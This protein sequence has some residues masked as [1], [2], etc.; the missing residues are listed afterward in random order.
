MALDELRALWSAVGVDCSRRGARVKV[1]SD[2][3]SF[4]V[5]GLYRQQGRTDQSCGLA[6]TRSDSKSRFGYLLLEQN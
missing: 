5:A 4:T 1:S 2:L 3:T 6:A